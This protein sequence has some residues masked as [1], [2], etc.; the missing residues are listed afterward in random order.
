MS[1]IQKLRKS[2]KISLIYKIIAVISVILLSSYGYG[3][4]ATGKAPHAVLVPSQV[5]V[6]PGENVTFDA[7]N[8]SGG[9]LV[10]TWQFHDGT[11]TLQ[12]KDLKIVH[13][14]FQ[15]EGIYYITLFVTARNAKMDMAVARVVV[16][17][18]PPIA[19][20]NKEQIT[21]EEDELI[22]FDASSS[23]DPDGKIIAYHWD[24]GD[25]FTG[26]GAIVNH[27]YREE[28]TYVANLTVTDEFGKYAYR[29]IIVNVRNLA[30]MVTVG[31]YTAKE[32]FPVYMQAKGKDTSSDSEGLRYLWSN[33]YRGKRAMEVYSHG[34]IYHPWVRVTD[35]D[36]A[37]STGN[38]TVTVKNTK[39]LI[40][41]DGVSFTANLTLRI[42]G[43]KGNTVELY[44]YRNGKLYGH[45]NVTRHPG[46]PQ[47]ATIYNI[48]FSLRDTWEVKLVYE[49]TTYHGANPAWIIL[50]FGNGA[51]RK[52]HHTFNVV[53]PDTY[54]WNVSLNK[55]FFS[56]GD[57]GNPTIRF[58]YKLYDSGADNL[59]VLW[60]IGNKIIT[61]DYPAHGF[62]NFVDTYLNA[63]PEDVGNITVE[64]RDN[65]GASSTVN[66]SLSN[67]GE[68]LAPDVEAP[69]NFSG[70]E[71]SPIIF[72]PVSQD[73]NL[74]YRWVL[75]DGNIVQGDRIQHSYHFSGKYPVLLI[76]RNSKGVMGF[77]LTWVCIYNKQPYAQFIFNHT[78]EDSPTVFKVTQVRDTPSD[79]PYLEYTWYFG[80]GT[81]GYGKDVEHVYHAAGNYTVKLVVVDDDGYSFTF[82]RNV[83]IRNVAPAVYA[84]SNLVVYGPATSVTLQAFA[85]DTFSHR[86]VEY[87]WNMGDGTV[88]EGKNITHIYRQSGTYTVKL[89]VVDDEGASTSVI[90]LVSVGVD[91][92]VDSLTDELERRMGTDPD[93]WDSDGDYI[94]DY[95]EIYTYGTDPSSRDSDHDGL[96]DWFEISYMGYKND[97]D[98]DGIKNPLD[99][100]SDG[101][102]IPD[103][104]EINEEYQMFSN[105]LVYSALNGS[106]W[107]HYDYVSVTTNGTFANRASV[108][109]DYL[110]NSGAK[111]QIY[112]WWL[113]DTIVINVTDTHV[114]QRAEIR[115][116]YYDDEID[117]ARH[118]GLYRLLPSGEI[119]AVNET[120]TDAERN[121]I[122]ARVTNP[123]GNFV[124]VYLGDMDSDGDGLSDYQELQGWDTYWYSNGTYHTM[125][126]SSDPFNPDSDGDGLNDSAEYAQHL[127]PRNSD[128]DGD[129]LTDSNEL[130]TKVYQ[131]PRRVYF[132]GYAVITLNITPDTS[133]IHDAKIIWGLRS[134]GTTD[135]AILLKHTQLYYQ[136]GINGVYFGSANISTSQLASKTRATV[137]LEI[138]GSGWLE[139]FKVVM[140]E[141]TDPHTSDSDSDGLSDG[142]EVLGKSGYITNPLDVDTDHDGLWDSEEVHGWSWDYGYRIPVPDENGFHTNPV[143]N[144]TDGDGYVDSN[145]ADPLHN[146][147]LKMTLDKYVW[148]EHPDYTKFAG[149]YAKW[150]LNG[151]SKSVKYYTEHKDHTQN[152][153]G[154]TYWFDVPDDVYTEI[155]VKAAAFYN[156][157]GD[158]KLTEGDAS[159]AVKKGLVMYINEDSNNKYYFHTTFQLKSLERVH[160]VAIYNNT[161]WSGNGYL[162]SGKYYVLYVNS[163]STWSVGQNINNRLEII[164]ER[165]NVVLIPAAIFVNSQL[166]AKIQSND[167]SYLQGTE[168]SN[169]SLG[170]ITTNSSSAHLVGMF[171][172]YTNATQVSQLF[173]LLCHNLSNEQFAH[174]AVITP[175]AANL[176]ADIL[177][178]I[179]YQEIQNSKTGG[180][181]KDLW[182][183]LSGAIGGAITSVVNFIY[184]GLIAL[185]NLIEQAINV[186]VQF[187]LKLW[188]V[189]TEAVKQAVEVVKNIYA[190][191][192]D[193]ILQ[194]VESILKEAMKE[195]YMWGLGNTDFVINSLCKQKLFLKIARDS[196]SNDAS[197]YWVLDLLQEFYN[198]LSTFI[199]IAFLLSTYI[200]KFEIGY[201][202]LGIMFIAFPSAFQFSDFSM[203]WV[204]SFYSLNISDNHNSSISKRLAWG[205]AMMMLASL[206]FP[207]GFYTKVGGAV[208][209]VATGGATISISIGGM[210]LEFIAAGL[211]IYGA[212]VIANMAPTPDELWNQWFGGG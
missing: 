53:H 68:F 75:G 3:I 21:A 74:N 106:D 184:R 13:H 100:D 89:T 23:H 199:S 175:E 91:S 97:T 65:E 118:P 200:L 35:N 115:L 5:I 210:I 112:A 146:L 16:R 104:A 17:D 30:P 207:T 116:H 147:V 179:P 201:L 196:I 11:P 101:D 124:V 153:W 4:F 26:E 55:Y 49:P 58:H 99:W 77:D 29:N 67:D 156:D 129:G 95:W 167:I 71:D 148:N 152:L 165:L 168:P 126:V 72:T 27:S 191:L 111:P 117:E 86:I 7:S 198:H 47:E 209:S 73:K 193:H 125:H 166:Y 79:L 14:S 52:I 136:S 1:A 212:L 85:S 204:D 33:G 31:N 149:F 36:N 81:V 159:F 139:S 15:K 123:N 163:S 66:I 203:V 108:V 206:L 94:G 138:W 46:P 169:A 60:H 83:S 90:S 183:Q 12:G 28:G 110:G 186:T 98:N 76:G 44:L 93:R 182:H 6:S 141:C 61:R 135:V 32:G 18:L 119:E 48:T 143:S 142:Y 180:A 41:V 194:D 192:R 80:D 170:A 20:V 39:P 2:S 144:D 40:D 133:A 177:Q 137:K 160:T 8:S 78:L 162:Y 10:Y 181:P 120:G 195:L 130:Y 57:C 34:G 157:L 38:A 56:N 174:Y 155:E 164:N 208:G 43:R 185:A 59:T 197:I 25:G 202:Y 187:F 173:S 134:N 45:L 54:H 151:D 64:V 150:T 158:N 122:W 87:R 42:A 205:L 19:V 114:P 132:E 84:P 92:D 70:Y 178:T 63:T 131:Y 189:T 9:D 82:K 37:S 176:P 128:T 127:D 62:P 105:P 172:F 140:V 171:F 22:K 24:F 88:V 161:V 69:A 109:V 103:G 121:I 107:G 96:D 190:V 154:Y 113:N 188:H 145:D 50:D 211:T 51:W 102:M